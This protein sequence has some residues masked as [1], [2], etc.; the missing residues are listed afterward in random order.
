M[1]IAHPS[2]IKPNC[3]AV[4]IFCTDDKDCHLQCGSTALSVL[5]HTMTLENQDHSG[6][7][8]YL[9]NK[10]TKRC[11]PNVVLKG[12]YD[13]AVN[14][15]HRLL[16]H[17]AALS[18][19][20]QSYLHLY[21]GKYFILARA[22]FYESLSLHLRDN[23]NLERAIR[24]IRTEHQQHRR[25]YLNEKI[26]YLEKEKIVIDKNEIQQMKKWLS[27][28]SKDDRDDNKMK[29]KIVVDADPTLKSENTITKDTITM[30]TY[31][32]QLFGQPMPQLTSSKERVLTRAQE[33]DDR[34]GE[35]ILGIKKQFKNRQ[36]GEYISKAAMTMVSN[37]RQELL[38]NQSPSASLQFHCNEE[39]GAGIMMAA[40]RDSDGIILPVCICT[41]PLYLTGPTCKH[42][43]YN[44]VIDYEQWE[45]I[46]VPEFL[47]D[48]FNDY[49]K[50]NIVCKKTTL[51]TTA[52]FEE[53][54][55]LFKCQPLAAHIAQSLQ[56]RGPYEPAL[57]LDRDYIDAFNADQE[58]KFKINIDYLDLLK[59][60]W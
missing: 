7:T 31:K 45:E 48:P 8:I 43:T 5:S 44:N 2:H 1:N 60:F 30:D 16:K 10:T 21:D 3:S 47:I 11:E 23:E 4:D 52:V 54:E 22:R 51:N 19:S 27:F 25:T 12:F 14:D 39:M 46:G 38:S 35:Y 57:I 50:A 59:K 24:D 29:A 55:G 9:C 53:R 34:R 58:T 37:Q 18:N 33:Y 20:L 56:L 42:R 32:Q 40:F 13:M 6:V 28:S 17:K 49:K 15:L 26:K 36:R 41:H